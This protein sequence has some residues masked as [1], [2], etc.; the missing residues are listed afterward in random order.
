MSRMV[1]R[2]C[3]RQITVCCLVCSVFLVLVLKRPS[4]NDYVLTVL[5]NVPQT[6]LAAEL[7]QLERKSLIQDKCRDTITN[8]QF[9][10]S[11]QKVV[12][13]VM[14]KIEERHR[15]MY[16]DVPKVI[17]TSLRKMRRSD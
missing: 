16:C 13:P 4:L 12:T 5:K 2:F 7:R 1:S 6:E 17:S 11:K 3:L 8:V 9:K 15:I 10:Q 14:F